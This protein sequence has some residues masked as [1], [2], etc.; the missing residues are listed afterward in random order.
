M[1]I[2]TKPTMVSYIFADRSVHLSRWEDLPPPLKHFMAAWAARGTMGLTQKQMFGEIFNDFLVAH[3]LGHYLEH[4]SGRM[5]TL[6]TTVSETEANMIALAFWS[7]DPADRARL[8]MRYDNLTKFLF[9]QP[10]PVPPGQDPRA[11]LTQ[12]YSTISRDG[13][14]YGWYQGRFLHDAWE[15]RFERDFCGWVKANPPRPGTEIDR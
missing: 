4:M 12:N 13:S 6:D 5:Q 11:Y 10:D 8:S 7:I 15:R 14:A 3:E 2:D 1:V 9:E